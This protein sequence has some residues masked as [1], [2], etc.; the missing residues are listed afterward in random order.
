VDPRITIRSAEPGDVDVIV[1]L[2]TQL[3]YPT[4]T[5]EVASRLE[6]AGASG[7]HAVLVAEAEGEVAGWV[8]VHDSL[9]I[10]APPGAELS[11]IIVDEGS[12]GGGVGRALLAA[13]EEWA[14]SRG[15]DIIRIR[16]RTT[17]HHAHRFYTS[18]GYD[19]IK[20]SLV[21]EKRLG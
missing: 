16:S 18:A 14:R 6:A 8:H 11:G 21:F 7:S 4:T 5:T 19:E 17:R 12:R 9:L 2:S 15:H 13:A 3:G 20:T 10:Q 1:R